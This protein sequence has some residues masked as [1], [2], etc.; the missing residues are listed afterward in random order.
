MADRQSAI[1][2]RTKSG[3]AMKT[4]F[5]TPGKDAWHRRVSLVGT[6]LRKTPGYSTAAPYRGA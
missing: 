3:P 1:E 2:A 6:W 4:I 5:G